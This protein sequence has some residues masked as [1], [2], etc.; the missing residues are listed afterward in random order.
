[1]GI[2]VAVGVGVE[3]DADVQVGSKGRGRGRSTGRLINKKWRP[4]KSKEATGLGLA[5]CG[6]RG[7]SKSS[8]VLNATSYAAAS[9]KRPSATE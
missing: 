8:V 2:R 3:V 6:V 5:K 4:M 9:C 7:R 1:M